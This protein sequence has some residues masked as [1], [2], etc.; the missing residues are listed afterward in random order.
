[1]KVSCNPAFIHKKTFLDFRQALSCIIHNTPAPLANHR[2]TK[3][4]CMKE[5]D[6]LS[7]PEDVRYS[8]DHEWARPEGELFVV[9]ISDYAQDQLG[10]IVFVELPAKGTQ[11]KK[12]DEFGSVESVKAVSELFMPMGGEVVALNADVEDS[13][14]LVASAPYAGGWMIKIKPSRPEEYDELMDRAAYLAML[15]G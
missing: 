12:G 6:E 2:P 4:V 15:K 3:E 7:F 13:P 8:K 5:I 9:G 11:L 1:M 14:E 10:D